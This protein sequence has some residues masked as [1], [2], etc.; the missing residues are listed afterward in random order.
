MD[1]TKQLAALDSIDHEAIQVL[2]FKIDAWVSRAIGLLC[3]LLS[4][5]SMSRLQ[6]QEIAQNI[7]QGF[8]SSSSDA[9][10]VRPTPSVA[11]ERKR[12]KG[13]K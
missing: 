4:D 1:G 12:G 5:Y 3:R 13:T 2:A 11:R 10:F 6:I 7:Q 9:Q 8:R